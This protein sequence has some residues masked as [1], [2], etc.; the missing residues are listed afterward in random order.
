MNGLAGQ[1]Q[2]QNMQVQVQEVARLLEQGI[3]PEELMQQGVPKEIIELALRTL[4]QPRQQMMQ[5]PANG[6][7]AQQGLLV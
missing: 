6:L 5:E 3:S 4:Q 2:Q 7:A 1:G